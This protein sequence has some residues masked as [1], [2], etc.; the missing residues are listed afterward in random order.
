MNENKYNNIFIILNYNQTI[1][2]KYKKFKY[3]IIFDY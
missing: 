2:I 3:L 1:N